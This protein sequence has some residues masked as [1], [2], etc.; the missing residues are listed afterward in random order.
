ME[1]TLRAA[2]SKKKMLDKQIE[3]MVSKD[4][5]A[6]VTPNTVFIEGIPKKTWEAKVK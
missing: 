2:L 4:L 5:F 6:V 1:M 3:D